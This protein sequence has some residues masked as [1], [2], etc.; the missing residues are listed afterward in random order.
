MN[1][2]DIME[3]GNVEM[4]YSFSVCLKM[5]QCPEY[6]VSKGKISCKY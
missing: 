6:K 1:E 5:L 2:R 4:L 3:D